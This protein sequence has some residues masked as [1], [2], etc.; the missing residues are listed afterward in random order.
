MT[1]EWLSVDTIAKELDVNIDTVRSWI[2]QKKLRAYKV[3]R[4][5][6]I[7][8]VDYDKFLEDRATLQDEDEET[9]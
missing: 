2:R 7:K 8:R 3:G 6:R 4:D 5:Y 1:T 9:R